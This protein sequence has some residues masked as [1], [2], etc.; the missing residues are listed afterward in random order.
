MGLIKYSVL[1]K[2]QILLSSA[3]MLGIMVGHLKHLKLGI[4]YMVIS[5]VSLE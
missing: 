3:L 2:V 5:G 4:H 1:Q